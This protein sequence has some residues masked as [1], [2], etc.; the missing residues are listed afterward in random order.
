MSKDYNLSNFNTL[1]NS[2]IYSMVKSGMIMPMHVATGAPGSQPHE[3]GGEYGQQNVKRVGGYE[4]ISD[5]L[6]ASAT[7]YPQIRQIAN[8]Y[9]LAKATTNTIANTVVPMHN[10]QSIRPAIVPVKP[11]TN[12][13]HTVVP[14]H[15][16]QNTR[17][18][19]RIKKTP[20]PHKKDQYQGRSLRDQEVTH[21]NQEILTDQ[22]ID[23]KR[24]ELTPKK[25]RW[26][27]EM[28][29]V[30]AIMAQATN[31]S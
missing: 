9:G 25:R 13:Q 2:S 16:Q 19:Q 27:F 7:L 12:T 23:F 18:T 14:I 30:S 8:I 6:L 24:D 17:S 1:M 28:P 20:T 4:G 5:T 29:D 22:M 21:T 15:N 26:L 3:E 11:R 10:Q 31:K